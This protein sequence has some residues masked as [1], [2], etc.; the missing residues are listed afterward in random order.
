MS[1]RRAVTDA[2]ERLAFA[3]TLLGDPRARTWASAAW[4]VRSLKG[5]V[6]AMHAD[7]SL[8]EV[9]GVGEGVMDVVGEVLTGERPEALRR[10]EAQIPEGLFAIRRIKGLGPKKIAALFEQLG[11]ATLGEL[12]YACLE[13]RLVD[14]KGFGAKTQA[15]VLAQIRAIRET[16][17]LMRRDQAA[18][19][20]D[21]VLAHVREVLGARAVAVGEHARGLE[22]VR[23]LAVLVETSDEAAARAAVDEARPPETEV[24]A[25]V[26]EPGRFGVAE[27]W[28]T[29][30]EGHRARMIERAGALG[31]VLD[32]GGLADDDGELFCATAADVYEALGLVPTAVERRE[33]RVPLVERG[34]AA[35]ELVTRAALRGALHNHTIAS[36][37]S[38]SL[39]EMR[40]AAAAHGLSYLGISEHS[41]SAF[42][43]RGLDEER[44][45]AQV[46]AIRA[47]RAQDEDGCVLL[48]GVESD[49]LADGSLDYA[50]DLL[51]ELDVVIAS[52]HR[53]H[54]QGPEAM[55]ARMLAAARH[56]HTDVVGH[57]TGRLLLGRPPSEYD[58]EAFLDACAANDVA[59]ELNANPHRLDLNE[60]HLAMAKERGVL[61]SIAADAHATRELDHL[62]HGVTLARRAGLGPEDVLNARTLDEL[63]A[64][65]DARRR[66]WSGRS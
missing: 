32:E 58:V 21:A 56:P 50:P 18:A 16:E 43:A 59:V 45:R 27:L 39:E 42:Y 7:G 20:L 35:P 47:L 5:D 52:V 54:G 44:L 31:M 17:G 19:V 8:A 13:N 30:S 38:A 15:K 25:H 24:A 28:R 62:E 10:M 61:V 22:L 63:R 57:P 9:R 11:V 53:R 51:D 66:G 4:A 41:R 33:D 23:E 26:A 6:E 60:V 64:W 37:G 29:S 3:A 36:D 46:E 2:L 49:I 40:D 14:L 1:A 55:T 34:R 48:T 65:R 12:E